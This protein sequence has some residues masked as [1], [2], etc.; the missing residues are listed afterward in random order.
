MRSVE[1]AIDSGRPPRLSRHACGY[2]ASVEAR[3]PADQVFSSLVIL[4][5]ASGTSQDLLTQ[6]NDRD[7]AL[8]SLLVELNVLLDERLSRRG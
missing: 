7:K 1:F 3:D 6:T 2:S 5:A 4:R 8:A